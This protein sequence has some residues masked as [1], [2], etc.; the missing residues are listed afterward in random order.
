[1]NKRQENMDLPDIDCSSSDDSSDLSK[2]FWKG[3]VVTQEPRNEV[4]GYSRS[5]NPFAY[6]DKE[7]NSL[8]ELHINKELC[9]QNLEDL[10]DYRNQQYMGMAGDKCPHEFDKKDLEENHFKILNVI[11]RN[12]RK[13]LINEYNIRQRKIAELEALL[14]E[15]KSHQS[16][17]EFTKTLPAI[18]PKTVQIYRGKDLQTYMND[19]ERKA[20]T[21]ISSDDVDSIQQ[22]YMLGP[23]L[24]RNE[25][26]TG[27]EREEITKKYEADCLERS[28][29]LA[30]QREFDETKRLDALKN[31][32]DKLRYHTSSKK[33]ED[34]NK[35]LHTPPPPT[36]NEVCADSIRHPTCN[37]KALNL[38][39]QYMTGLF[40]SPKVDEPKADVEKLI[41][42][43]ELITNPSVHESPFKEFIE[44]RTI[45]RRK[46]IDPLGSVFDH[47]T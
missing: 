17:Q 8:V 4:F 12:H 16:P 25:Y 28:Q 26:Y 32:M 21:G 24:G 15:M 11:E 6:A 2:T 44:K 7:F 39:W 10:D 47:N 13:H 3:R 34:K 29:K 43:K 18:L 36:T 23:D 33:T 46:H 45:R 22:I 42:D 41:Q 14:A 20:L 40:S 9:M 31:D 37:M 38:V 19:S 1:M 27:T 5:D 35:K 30:A